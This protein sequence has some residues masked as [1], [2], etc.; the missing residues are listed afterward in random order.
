MEENRNDQNT[1]DSV[2]PAPEN[3]G[4]TVTSEGAY[5][6]NIAEEPQKAENADEA[7]PDTV[8]QFQSEAPYRSPYTVPDSTGGS[9]F[10]FKSE[11]VS[12]PPEPKPK[13]SKNYTFK[14]VFFA[15]LIAAVIG[16]LGGLVGSVFIDDYFKEDD[17]SDQPIVNVTSPGNIDIDVSDVDATVVEAVATKVTPSVVG[18]RTTVSNYNFLY[19]QQESSGEGSGVIYTEDGYIITNYHVIQD[20]IENRGSN[21]AIQV[22]LSYGDENAEGYKAAVVGYNISYDLAVIKINAKGLTPIKITDSEKL[23]VGQFVVAIGNPGGL[24]FMGSVTYGVVSG[25]NRVISDTGVGSGGKL[26]QTDAA[27]NPGNSGGA[28]VNLNGELV[29]INSSKLVSESYEGMGFAIPSNTT[30]EICDKII[31]KENDPDPFLGITINNNYTAEMLKQYGYPAGAVV[32]SVVAGSPADA[33]GIQKNDIITEMNGVEI[34]DYTV[35]SKV[36]ADCK[37]GQK[38]TMKVFRKGNSYTLEVTL[39][40]NNSQ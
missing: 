13:K 6:E 37:P 35:I 25:L 23:K 17:L 30:R 20:A 38:I 24:Q 12:P 8:Q 10:T 39:G 33:A 32:Y 11:P 27:I 40:S 1:F 26:I 9:G 21:S 15:A 14:A 36:M 19:G 3:S 28:L 2:E 5:Y 31:S 34:T 4:Y 7:T 22:Y 16:M 18:I 29:G